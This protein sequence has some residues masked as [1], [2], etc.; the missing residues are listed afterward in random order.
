MG[1]YTKLY[2][3]GKVKKEY[4]PALFHV[5]HFNEIITGKKEELNTD[6]KFKTDEFSNN[7]WY[8]TGIDILMELS[9][10]PRTSMIINP[11]TKFNEKTGEIIIISE[12]KNY[13]C[14]YELF[15]KTC[16]EIMDDVSECLTQYEGDDYSVMYIF[17]KNILTN[18][19]DVQCKRV[20]I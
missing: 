4:I 8:T 9:K 6:N 18:K 13:E 5:V 1:M 14:T 2:F 15:F 10:D 11:C 20:N 3:T 19:L 16:Q 7:A 17:T 12:L